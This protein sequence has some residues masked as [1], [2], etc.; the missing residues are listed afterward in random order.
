MIGY[1]LSGRLLP[2]LIE[3]DR[4]RSAGGRLEQPITYWNAEGALAAVGLLLCA[5]LI[6]DRSRPP[7][8][9]AA[10][11]AASAPLG[12]GVY[13]SYSRGAIAVAVLGLVMLVAALP[14][15]RPAAAPRSPRFAAGAAASVAA[16]AFPGVAALEGSH[17]ERDGAVVLAILA[18]IAAAAALSTRTPRPPEQRDPAAAP[19]RA[20][21]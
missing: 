20:A 12:A 17:P 11:A 14:R 13:L 15:A 16:A 5:R 19:A 2:G 18:L 6:G 10:A 3:L 21:R 7:W 9:R 8:M 1:G 4:S